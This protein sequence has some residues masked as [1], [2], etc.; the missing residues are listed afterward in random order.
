VPAKPTTPK[1]VPRLRAGLQSRCGPGGRAH[2]AA[3]LVVMGDRRRR[4][5]RRANHDRTRIGPWAVTHPHP[6]PPNPRSLN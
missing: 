2:F 6:P 3:L 4:H 5:V 1:Q